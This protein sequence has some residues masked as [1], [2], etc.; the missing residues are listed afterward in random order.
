MIREYKGSRL[1]LI[2][3][4]G[5]RRALLQS[6]RGVDT[7]VSHRPGNGTFASLQVGKDKPGG[8]L[9]SLQATWQPLLSAIF[10]RYFC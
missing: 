10:K 1:L 5:D 6:F 2:S 4:F 9:G 3:K 8:V 7:S